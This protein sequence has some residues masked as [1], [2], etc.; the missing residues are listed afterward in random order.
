MELSKTA[1][2]INKVI[3]AVDSKG[4]TVAVKQYNPSNVGISSDAVT[5]MCCLK[6]LGDHEGIVKVLNKT[7]IYSDG[8][9]LASLTMKLYES[10]MSIFINHVC[11]A[12]RLKILTH[13]I[14]Q[15]VPTLGYI[16]SQ[17]IIHGD[18]KPQN[19]L[20]D[21]TENA[22][23]LYGDITC[24]ISD[25]GASRVTKDISIYDLQSQP[26]KSP[27]V[28]FEYPK[29]SYKCDIWAF[30]ITLLIYIMGIY[31]GDPYDNDNIVVPWIIRN[32]KTNKSSEFM[33]LIK[34]MSP[35]SVNHYNLLLTTMKDG[36]LMDT[37]DVKRVI[38][39]TRIK[40]EELSFIENTLTI[41]PDSRFDDLDYYNK[42]SIRPNDVIVK[43]VM[44]GPIA[45]GS[46]VTVDRYYKYIDFMVKISKIWNP[47]IISLVCGHDIADR[48][49]TIIDFTVDTRGKDINDI[50]ACFFICCLA[51][52]MKMVDTDDIDLPLYTKNMMGNLTMEDITLMEVRILKLLDYTLYHREIEV[53]SDK[54]SSIGTKALD[55]ERYERHMRLVDTIK[56]RGLYW[57]DID[58]HTLADM[59]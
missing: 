38:A 26:Y 53:Y 55:F 12:D 28:Q 47:K 39:P 41:N 32:L 15:V 57:G 46:I 16:H 20:M 8:L 23:T 18:I 5:E 13:I 1:K 6:K 29:P 34:D 33:K 49:L 59:L 44:R 56:D 3:I 31:I 19:I 43:Y 10:D 27:E 54:L 9:C 25:F 22:G 58:Y 30:G 37:I 36:H 4:V 21:Y 24:V 45:L 40:A 51:L 50:V 11:L 42:T 17:Q 2:S 48:A 14:N 35:K 52:G 7:V